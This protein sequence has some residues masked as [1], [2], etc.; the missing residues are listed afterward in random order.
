MVA[1]FHN[2]WVTNSKAPRA[3]PTLIHGGGTHVVPAVE[4]LESVTD[5]C[6]NA[7]IDAVDHTTLEMVLIFAM[8]C[9]SLGLLGYKGY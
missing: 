3:V 7:I 9:R 2:S 1:L 8:L 5:V 4:L 6:E